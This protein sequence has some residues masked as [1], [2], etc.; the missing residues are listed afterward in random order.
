MKEISKL[1]DNVDLIRLDDKEIYLV[2]TAHVS[3]SSVDLVAET[4]RDVKPDTVAVELCASRFQSLRDPERWKKM[5]IVT[6]IRTG[7]SYVLMA[8]L[9]IA[10]YQ[11]RIAKELGIKP[12]AEMLKA[13]DLA[14][15]LKLP[16]VLADRDIKT[17]L[18]RSWSSLGL[19]SVLKLFG[20]ALVGSMNAKKIGEKEIERLKTAD[21]LDEAMREF[22]EILPT[23][24]QTLIDERD[25]YLAAKVQEAP[26]KRIVAIVGA[27][28]V[29]GMKRWFGEKI[30]LSNLETIPPPKLS[31][32]I[33]TWGIPLLIIGM[34][35]FGFF[36]SGSATSVNMV[37]AWIAI[38]AVTAGFGAL[39]A[40]AHPFSIISAAV[41][42]PVTTLHPLLASGWFAGLAEAMLRKPTVGDFEDIGEDI[43]T[44]RG[45][46]RNRIS[47]VL[48]VI[49]LTNLMGSIGTFIGGWYLATYL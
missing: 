17:T 32:K 9:L 48:L 13:L 41:T 18:R 16:T 3:H 22:S 19:W 2:G 44:F 26:G 43:A 29:P 6:V 20:M 15:E 42:A 12:G 37:L 35:V 47:R 11:K 27:G 24:R 31:T 14:D 25:Q 5:D 38:T 23:V 7:K 28:H 36:H 49:A 34:I 30:D 40:L 10:G 4:L 45:L 33:M 21:A 46:Y 1:K 8:Q 39:L